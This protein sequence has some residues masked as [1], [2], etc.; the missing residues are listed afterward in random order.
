MFSVSL[1]AVLCFVW[2]GFIFFWIVCL[3]VVVVCVVCL[4]SLSFR[5]LRCCL[6][7]IIYSCCSFALLFGAFHYFGWLSGVGLLLVLLFL[8]RACCFVCFCLISDVGLCASYFVVFGT[9]FAVCFVDV[10][11]YAKVEWFCIVRLF[12]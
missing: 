2:G 3:F 8:F 1:R 11:V 12:S 5:R 7:C 10:F 4:S 6:L 9:V